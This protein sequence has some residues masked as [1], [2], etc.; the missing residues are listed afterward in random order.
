MDE[1]LKPIKEWIDKKADAD[2]DEGLALLSKFSKNR[3][4]IQALGRKPWPEKLRYELEKVLRLHTS[5][6]TIAQMKAQNKELEETGE[7]I[8]TAQIMG[9][10]LDRTLVMQKG[11]AL[12]HEELPEQL[13]PLHLFNLAGYKKVRSLHEK[14]KLMVDKPDKERKPIVEEL[15]GIMTQIRTNW[16]AIDAW[17][18]DETLPQGKPE[19][20]TDGGG[21]SGNFDAKAVTNARSYI[22][23]NI[24][25]LK[26]DEKEKYLQKVQE[27]V[28]V[29]LKAGEP[30]GDELLKELEELGVN[31]KA[32]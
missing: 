4:L 7:L 5:P 3:M 8:V 12:K 14:L 11:K 1:K 27:R 20:K 19:G 13:K 23:K 31:V 15:D 32:D 6:Q 2:Y 25:K 22:S 16:D 10:E 21:G 29:I 18:K 30:M 26:G 24:D 17:L 28:D 9:V